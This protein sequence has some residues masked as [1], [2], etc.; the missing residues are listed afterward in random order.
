MG[1]HW[2]C[3]QC[4]QVILYCFKNSHFN[5]FLVS[6]VVN[7][8]TGCYNSIS[9]RLSLMWW[10]IWNKSVKLLPICTK[11][12]F[13]IWTWNQVWKALFRSLICWFLENIVCVS[14]DSH[15]IKLIDFGLSRR[16]I[17]HQKLQVNF[18]TP[19]FVSPEVLNYNSVSYASD[20]WS[21]GVITYI[22]VSGKSQGYYQLY[23]P[24]T[25]V[26]LVAIIF[27]M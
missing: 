20:M 4:F 1:N 16:Y 7:F 24:M 17:P 10:S 5:K 12:K 25:T 26:V 14:P 9:I 18:G 3:S 27:S 2:P 22:L 15:H 11:I 8:L 19:E 13:Y 6:T 21:V 23:Y